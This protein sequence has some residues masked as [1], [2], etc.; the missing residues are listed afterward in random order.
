MWL[1]AVA[2]VPR[3]V[4]PVVAR[5][6]PRVKLLQRVRSYATRARHMPGPGGGRSTSI[7]MGDVKPLV[8]MMAFD[9]MGGSNSPSKSTT[10][11]RLRHID[12]R[13]LYDTGLSYSCP[14]VEAVFEHKGFF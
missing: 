3:P 10:A 4:R 9:A 6:G 13:A 1:I 2:G 8:A 12:N 5:D 14:D 11:S 7:G